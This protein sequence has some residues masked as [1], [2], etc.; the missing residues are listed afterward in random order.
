MIAAARQLLEL[1]R[2]S[3]LGLGRAPAD[4]Q[5]DYGTESFTVGKA[6]QIREGKDAAV[7]TYGAMV[8]NVVKAAAMLEKKG[9]SITIINMHTLK[10]LDTECIDRMIEECQILVS[11]EEES[12]I[13]GLGGAMAEYLAE[14]SSRNFIFRRMGIPDTYGDV[15]GTQAYMHKMYQIDAESIA[16]RIAEL[17]EEI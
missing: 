15:I 1:G 16:G 5:A 4:Y 8:P 7:F 10:P 9:I 6:L 3:Y 12:V 11:V 13:G 14:K 2:P 17:C